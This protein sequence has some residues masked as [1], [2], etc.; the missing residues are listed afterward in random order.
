MDARI[1]ETLLTTARREARRAETSAEH[2]KWVNTVCYIT[3]TYNSL[4]RDTDHDELR[5]QVS[6]MQEKVSKI[7][8]EKYQRP[9]KDVVT[10]QQPAGQPR[11]TEAVRPSQFLHRKSGPHPPLTTSKKAYWTIVA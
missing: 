3:Q 4:L 1:L 8:N 7:A 6:I 9:G 10:D 5:H 2:L 11:A